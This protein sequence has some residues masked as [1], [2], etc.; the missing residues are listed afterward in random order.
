M[1]YLLV[2]LLAGCITVPKD[3]GKYFSLEHGQ[4]MFGD[5]LS[6]A[7][8]HCKAM[9]MDTRHMGTDHVGIY[10]VSRFECVQR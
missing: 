4:M 10:S 2:L 1:R 3:A 6:A 9:G 5:A 7:R 8:N